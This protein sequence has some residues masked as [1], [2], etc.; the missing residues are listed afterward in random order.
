MRVRWQVAGWVL[1]LCSLACAKTG[2]MADLKAQADE[3]HGADQ[4]RLCLEYAHGELE[5]AN[6]LFTSGDVDQAQ[7][8]VSTAMEYARKGTKAATSSG[9]R[10]KQTEIDL[11]KL[12]KRMAD[13]AASLNL[14]DRPP[15]LKSVEELDQLRAD[16]ITAMFGKSAE[17]KG[18]S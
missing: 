13:V 14:D 15:L 9:K 16:L 11:R 5:Y 1:L 7:S 18:K 17:P 3:A 8:A 2:T 6:A 12:E 10:L 4:A